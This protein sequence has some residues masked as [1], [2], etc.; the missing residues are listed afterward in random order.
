VVNSCAKAPVTKTSVPLNL[1]HSLDNVCYLD[2]TEIRLL[3]FE[4]P[5]LIIL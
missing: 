4:V 2:S 1:P 3:L 5:N